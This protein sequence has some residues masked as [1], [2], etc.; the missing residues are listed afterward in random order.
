MKRDTNKSEQSS[1]RV[2]KAGLGYTIGN[3]LLKGLSF[4]T[5]PIFTRLLT[6]QDYGKYNVFLSYE[7]I[8]FVLIGFAIHSSYKNARYKYGLCSEGTEKGKDYYSYVS[9]TIC[10]ILCSTVGWLLFV[11]LFSKPLENLLQLDQ[12]CLNLLILYA[13]GNAIMTCYN[14]DAGLDYKYQ[15]FI[16]VSGINAVLN[17]LVSLVLI[18]FVF[19]T[20]KYIGRILGSTVAIVV[21]AVNII[22]EFLKRSTPGKDPSFLKW[23]IKYSAPII[24]HG[25]SQIVLNQFDRIM[26]MKMETEAR[27]GIYSFAYNIYAIIQVTAN[28]LD[29]VWGPWFYQKRK[30]NDLD[31]IKKYSGIYAFYMMIFSSAIIFMTPEIVKILANENYWDAIYSVIPIV[32]GGYFAFLYTIPSCVEYYHG[33]TQYIASGTML[34]AVINIVLNYIFIKRYGYVAA[35]YTTLAT[36]FLYFL[37]HYLIAMKIEKKSLFSNRIMMQCAVGMFVSVGLG[38]VLIDYIVV[39]IFVVAVLF[40]IGLIHEEKTFGFIS[41]FGGLKQWKKMH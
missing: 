25:L 41:R 37:F 22:T 27:A 2:L 24:P 5:I 17:I 28:S 9:T 33:K 21:V 40:L 20:D 15:R 35:A 23:G 14:T 26:I 36:Y 10:L 30:D 12:F 7:N 13:F 34:A 18:I 11:N 4:F 1:N 32:A 6:T 39:R 16:K 3:Y 38:N 8:I 31:A 29:N 19:Q